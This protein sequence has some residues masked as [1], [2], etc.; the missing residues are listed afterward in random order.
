MTD[1][2]DAGG[3]KAEGETIRPPG[4][5]RFAEISA[6]WGSEENRIDRTII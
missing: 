2:K 1:P 4:R 6:L 5:N 3:E